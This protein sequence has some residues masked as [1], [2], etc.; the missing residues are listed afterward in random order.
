MIKVPTNTF[1][2]NCDHHCA[3]DF[4]NGAGDLLAVFLFRSL[5]GRDLILLW[6]LHRLPFGGFLGSVVYSKTPCQ[7]LIEM[8]TTC[9][10]SP[11]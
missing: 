2:Q 9:L 5:P 8:V 11:S 7:L 10:A 4:R 3:H 6:L 1:G